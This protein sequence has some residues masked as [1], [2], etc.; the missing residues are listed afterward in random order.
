MRRWLSILLLAL[1][2]AQ[3]SWAAVAGYCRHEANPAAAHPGHHEH[4][5]PGHAEGIAG[6]PADTP[7]GAMLDMD[8]GHCQGHCTGL[9]VTPETACLDTVSGRP[10]ADADR[11]SPAPAPMPPERPQWQRLA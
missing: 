3:F 7:D 8:C 1:L 11:L 2:P 9:P 5:Q 4:S 10:V 6:S